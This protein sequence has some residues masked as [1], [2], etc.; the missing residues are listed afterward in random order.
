MSITMTAIN[1]SEAFWSAA[2]DT[3][4]DITAEALISYERCVSW[5]RDLHQSTTDPSLQRLVSD[6][7]SDLGGLGPVRSD[8][9]LESLVLGA[10]SSVEIAFE[11]AAQVAA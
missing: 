4:N 8:R 2:E 7:R 10:L 11:V 6:V 9:E 1:A 5:L 3:G